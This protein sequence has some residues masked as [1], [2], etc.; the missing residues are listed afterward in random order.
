MQQKHA[1]RLHQEPMAAAHF[2]MPSAVLTNN[3]AVLPE[4]Y[5]TMQQG[6]AERS[7]VLLSFQHMDRLSMGQLTSTTASI[8]IRTLRAVHW[9]LVGKLAVLSNM[10]HAV[11]TASTAVLDKTSVIFHL[12]GVKCRWR[13]VL[14]RYVFIA[15][16]CSQFIFSVRVMYVCNFLRRCC[17]VR[18]CFYYYQR[19]YQDYSGARKFII[20]IQC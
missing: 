19:F 11:K 16:K 8:V 3:T 2:P 6:C 17:F 20:Y 12:G 1:A 15:T 13:S 7:W 18:I 14:F 9:W 4:P 10:V 5:V